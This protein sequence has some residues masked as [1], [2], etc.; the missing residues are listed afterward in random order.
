M[1][2]CVLLYKCSNLCKL[3]PPRKNKCPHCHRC[4]RHRCHR[5]REPLVH[6]RQPRF[7][8]VIVVGNGGGSV[9]CC[10]FSHCS[11]SCMC[12]G[13]ATGLLHHPGGGG[14]RRDSRLQALRREIRVADAG[15]HAH[16]GRALRRHRLSA[17]QENGSRPGQNQCAAS[18]LPRSARWSTRCAEAVYPT[19]SSCCPMCSPVRTPTTCASGWARRIP[20]RRTCWDNGPREGLSSMTKPRESISK[21]KSISQAMWLERYSYTYS[22][23]FSGSRR[24]LMFLLSAGLITWRRSARRWP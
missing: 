19:T 3:P 20:T 22:L 14:Q 18:R 24:F 23:T 2:I 21:H 13:V 16:T 4:H 6:T 8:G 1:L 7:Y 17:S 9:A 5:W 11:A 10:D 12:C 15:L